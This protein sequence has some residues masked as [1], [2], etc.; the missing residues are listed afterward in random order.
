MEREAPRL[1]RRVPPV[2]LA[3]LAHREL[4]DDDAHPGEAVAA[5][6]GV[7]GDLAREVAAHRVRGAGIARDLVD[8][9]AQRVGEL[10]GQARALAPAAPVPAHRARERRAV[11]VDV[12]EA[13]SEQ[14]D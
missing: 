12:A 3:E 2:S 11:R 8:G 7:L 4:P 10:L 1:L 5:L 14:E 13:V 6:R 9:P